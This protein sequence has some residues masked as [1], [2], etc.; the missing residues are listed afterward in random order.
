MGMQEGKLP[1]LGGMSGLPLRNTSAVGGYDN[2]RPDFARL[3][4]QDQD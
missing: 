4:H 3:V 1:V 2:A